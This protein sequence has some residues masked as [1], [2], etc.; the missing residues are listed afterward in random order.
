MRLSE[1]LVKRQPRARYRKIIDYRQRN[2]PLGRNRE[3]KN[4]TFPW[5]LY[6]KSYNCLVIVGN[7]ST[8]SLPVHGVSADSFRLNVCRFDLPPVSI[9]FVPKVFETVFPLPRLSPPSFTIFRRLFAK[10]DATESRV[11]IALPI[12]RIFL[13]HFQLLFQ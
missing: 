9:R 7:S 1:S 8:D 6:A 2:F 3:S 12:L 10:Q 4:G 13:H 5:R 11:N